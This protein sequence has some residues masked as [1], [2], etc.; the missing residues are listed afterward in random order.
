[1]NQ[2]ADMATG[3]SS[4][5][6]EGGPPRSDLPV[7]WIDQPWREFV[8]PIAAGLRATLES[9]PAAG[10]A[11]RRHPEAVSLRADPPTPTPRWSFLTRRKAGAVP[12]APAPV[13]IAQG[14]DPAA[15]LS[16]LVEYLSGHAPLVLSAGGA[17]D[18]VHAIAGKLFAAYKVEGGS[19]RLSGCALEDRP[20]ARVTRLSEQGD[21]VRHTFFD[22][23][24][25]PVAVEEAQK[26]GLLEANAAPALA[27]P[28]A[29]VQWQTMLERAG[30]DS[31][32]PMSACVVMAKH[33]T[34]TLRFEREGCETEGGDSERTAPQVRIS[35][36]ARTL[37]PAP[38]VCPVTGSATF[39]LVPLGDGTLA[40]AEEVERCEITGETLLR[41]DLVT[42]AASG[43][44]ADRRLCATCPVT[45]DLLLRSALV[46]CS[47]CG[48]HVSAG[49]LVRK[50]CQGCRAVRRGAEAQRLVAALLP[51]WPGLRRYGRWAT[52]STRG[53]C[54][55]QGRRFLQR[56]R[57][58]TDPVGG[59]V[60]RVLV[61]AAPWRP[62]QELTA[63][64]SL[65][66]QKP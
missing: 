40:A 41:R 66:L 32:S 20:F 37:A 30:A 47:G 36:W 35:G 28:S 57:L 10:L 50:S 33:A 25:E 26:L 13:A 54:V 61:S 64:Q 16:S 65:E 5:A 46:R 31:N 1:M 23:Q 63:E 44:R 3:R 60:R 21:G 7:E 51:A 55:L 24:G 12:P 11:V 17:P 45:G 19:A 62:F 38:V 8:E 22:P 14:A 43:K 9:D 4:P 18:S 49:A 29:Q 15:L 56:V 39:H 53:A 59:E 34:C 58:V 6:I 27:S 52:T 42:C 48:E 2:G